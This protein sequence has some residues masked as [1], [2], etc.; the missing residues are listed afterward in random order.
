MTRL[1]LI[2]FDEAHPNVPHDVVMQCDHEPTEAQA[3]SAVHA[4]HWTMG[5][6]WIS[7]ITETS[8]SEM[9]GK[10]YILVGAK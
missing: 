8:E 9:R 5:T 4:T 2:D 3:E 10:E 6:V 1:W 7:S